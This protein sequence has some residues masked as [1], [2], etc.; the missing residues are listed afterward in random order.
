MQA[1]SGDLWVIPWPKIYIE[2]LVWTGY[3]YFP[4]KQKTIFEEIIDLRLKM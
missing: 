2:K 4:L 1:E 3:K